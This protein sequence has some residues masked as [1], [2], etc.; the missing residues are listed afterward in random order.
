M[1]QLRDLIRNPRAQVIVLEQGDRVVAYAIGLIRRHRNGC[2]G[3]LYAL[4][5]D[6]AERG[7]GFGRMMVEKVIGAMHSAGVPRIYLE[8]RDNNETAIQLYERLG[9][10][11]CGYLPNYYGP[12]IDGY[13]MRRTLDIA[14]TVPTEAPVNVTAAPA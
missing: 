12:G 8:V 2:S 11:I 10:S 4:A 14:P 3:R 5:V 9:F 6:P 13:R 1:R 7:Q